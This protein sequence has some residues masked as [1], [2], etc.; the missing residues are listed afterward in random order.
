MQS[1]KLVKDFLP[2]KINDTDSS[3]CGIVIMAYD[4]STQ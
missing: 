3:A 2:K 1:F 4:T